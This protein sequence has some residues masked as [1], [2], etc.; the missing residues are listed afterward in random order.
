MRDDEESDDAA[1]TESDSV[2]SPALT[3]STTSSPSSL[4]SYKLEK[5]IIRM[6]TFNEEKELQRR[7]E[8]KKD[9]DRKGKNGFM[10]FVGRIK[11]SF[12]LKVGTP[13]VW[14]ADRKPAHYFEYLV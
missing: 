13:G 14:N 4:V 1:T 10:S 12:S 5:E 3:R 11:R 7:L 8:E 2:F 6:L 9:K